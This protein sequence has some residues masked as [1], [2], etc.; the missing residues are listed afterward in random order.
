[1]KDKL[2]QG[3]I[4]QHKTGGPH[5]TVDAVFPIRNEY[6][7]VGDTVICSWWDGCQFLEKEFGHDSLNLINEPSPVA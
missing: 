2:L 3:Q 5:M 1:M 6:G 7:A 4:V